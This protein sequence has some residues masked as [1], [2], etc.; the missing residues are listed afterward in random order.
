LASE[1][2]AR[3]PQRTTREVN[4]ENLS[5]HETAGRRLSSSDAEEEAAPHPE[6]DP[7]APLQHAGMDA[8]E[9]RM[10]RAVDS[11]LNPRGLS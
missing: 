10:R 2:G 11:I 1:T 6:A 9:G 7:P 8:G 3:P 4:R 5:V